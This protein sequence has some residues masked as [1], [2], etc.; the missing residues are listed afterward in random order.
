[1]NKDAYAQFSR[2]ID[3]YTKTPEEEFI[4]FIVLRTSP[5][6][7]QKA[8]ANSLNLP[9]ERFFSK[10]KTKLEAMQSS[11]SNHSTLHPQHP[12]QRQQPPYNPGNYAT[13]SNHYNS[14]TQRQRGQ[15]NSNIPNYH[16]ANPD[17]HI[18]CK[19]HFQYG[20][21]ARNCDLAECSMKH[22][23]P[24]AIQSFRNSPKNETGQ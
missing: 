2:A 17:R 9:Y 16:P 13:S 14:P 4:K 11:A 5:P 6:E 15:P 7:L 22:L 21:K 20:H 8:M 10:Y 1:L 3:L 23:V 19:Y 12:T 18:L 24:S